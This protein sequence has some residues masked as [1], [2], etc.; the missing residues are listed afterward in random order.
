MAS[1]HRKLKLAFIE[2]HE[3]GPVLVVRAKDNEERLELPMRPAT[4]RLLLKQL[5]GILDDLLSARETL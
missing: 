4:A 3:D 1:I 2:H 5:V